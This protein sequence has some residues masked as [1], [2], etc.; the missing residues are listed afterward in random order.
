[1]PI[2]AWLVSMF[3][4]GAVVGSF[5]NVCIY[6]IPFE[7]SIL[8]PPQ[9][10]CGRCLKPIA[11]YDNLPLLSYWLLRGRCRRCGARFSV[12]YFWVEL[13]TAVGFAGLFYLEAAG[14]TWLPAGTGRWPPLGDW[15]WA[16]AK[17]IIFG[18]HAV[19]FSFLVVTS[20]CDLDHQEIPLP[21][22]ITGTVVGLLGGTLLWPLVPAQAYWVAGPLH[23]PAPGHLVLL[24]GLYPWPVWSSDWLSSPGWLTG[25][26]TALAG[27]LAGM[28]LL[29]GLRFLFGMV[30]GKEG[31]G[32]GDADLMMMAGSFLGWQPV[33]VALFVAALPG[34]FFGIVQL[35]SRGGQQLPFGPSLAIGL[36]ATWLGWRYLSPQLEPVFFDI[37]LVTVVAVAGAILL[38]VA[39]LLLRLL[40]GGAGEQPDT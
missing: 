32:L 9:S 15:Y 20:F 1:M 13:L 21:I 33:I 2:Y 19:L 17:V 34:L 7:K 8:W 36:M 39:G 3:V 23:V 10:F 30:R 18:F 12:R 11:W 25:L 27:T 31:M 37:V 4:L 28:V 35:L 5:L 38:V 24:S 26:V 22:T 40:L 6:R 14:P 29:R 16:D